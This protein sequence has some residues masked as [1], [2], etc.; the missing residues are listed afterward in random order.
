MGKDWVP[1]Y[2]LMLHATAPSL[3]SI[4]TKWMGTNS[5]GRCRRYLGV[6]KDALNVEVRK[7]Y[8]QQ[9][10]KP[11]LSKLV[12]WPVPV[13]LP[14]QDVSSYARLERCIR[15]ADVKETPGSTVLQ[16]LTLVE[17]ELGRSKK[18]SRKRTRHGCYKI[19]NALQHCFAEYVS[20][21]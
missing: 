4:V 13:F 2:N 7:Q 12:K 15:V 17:L 3:S 5:A 9:D 1:S 19:N 21:R 8:A 16:A 11:Y 10:F 18:S 6:K 14:P 20:S